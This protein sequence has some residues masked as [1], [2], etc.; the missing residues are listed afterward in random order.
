MAKKKKYR[1]LAS[2]T[3]MVLFFPYVGQ[4]RLAI[5]V[6]ITKGVPLESVEVFRKD[7]SLVLY[8]SLSSSIISQLLCLLPSAALFMLTI[9]PFGSCQE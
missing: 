9:W 6:K 1:F 8:F 5:A 3:E 4:T 7:P 2:S